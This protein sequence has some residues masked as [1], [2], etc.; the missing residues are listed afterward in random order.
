MPAVSQK[1]A[2][3]FKAALGDPKPGTGAAKIKATVP[4]EKIKDFTHTNESDEVCDTCNGQGWYATGETNKPEQK[5]C[6]ACQGTGK[7]IVDP[8]NDRE[9]S[10]GSPDLFEA[11]KKNKLQEIIRATIKEVLSEEFSP[12]EKRAYRH[13]YN[14]QDGC[15]TTEDWVN[16][17]IAALDQAGLRPSNQ[18]KLRQ[19]IDTF[20]EISGKI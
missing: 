17:A 1:Q 3:L 7:K 8:Y 9:V 11:T 14:V 18:L 6:D 13:I 5:Q 2:N 19:I 10:G 15:K 20:S 16:L 12:S 4:R